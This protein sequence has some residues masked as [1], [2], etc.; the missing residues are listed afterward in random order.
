MPENNDAA[1]VYM[2][3]RG[4]WITAGF[5]NVPFDVDINTV[6]NVMNLYDIKDK[7]GNLGKIII[8]C[9]RYIEG[10]QKKAKK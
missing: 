9:R 5:N 10:V 2:L 8:A 3:V 7:K 1:F 6:I 4:Q